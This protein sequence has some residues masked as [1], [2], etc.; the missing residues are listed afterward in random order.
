MDTFA[1][2]PN[3]PK[4]ETV[5]TDYPKVF[6]VVVAGGWL[7]RTETFDTL[8]FVPQPQI[9]YVPQPPPHQHPYTIPAFPTGYQ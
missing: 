5:T 8:V 4:W 2:Q 1:P 3:G 6:R 7:Y 9:T